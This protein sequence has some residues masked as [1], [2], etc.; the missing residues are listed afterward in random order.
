MMKQYSIP[1]IPRKQQF[2]T[3]IGNS[4]SIQSK[5]AYIRSQGKQIH[6]L[7]LVWINYFYLLFSPFSIAAVLENF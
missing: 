6:K 1:H 4:G 2:Q 5:K 3:H 7:H